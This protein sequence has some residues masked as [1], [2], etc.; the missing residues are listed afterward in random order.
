MRT[1]H[2]TVCISANAQPVLLNVN[3]GPSNV[4]GSKNTRHGGDSH[5]DLDPSR[6]QPGGP[7]AD[8]VHH[9]S[10]RQF[11]EP[12]RRDGP[13]RLP[14]KQRVADHIL[15]PQRVLSRP[16]YPTVQPGLRNRGQGQIRRYGPTGGDAAGRRRPYTGGYIFRSRP[17]RPGSR[18]VSVDDFAR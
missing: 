10:L 1:S 11:R 14:G 15:W 4:S 18:G 7:S 17:R 8:T 9:G 13:R 16:H 3:S 2:S 12:R 5:A 6:T